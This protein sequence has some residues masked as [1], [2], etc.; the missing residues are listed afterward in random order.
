MIWCHI[1]LYSIW[2]E[3]D[4]YGLVPLQDTVDATLLISCFS[5]LTVILLYRTH[6]RNIRIEKLFMHTK[7]N[8]DPSLW[9]KKEAFEVCNFGKPVVHH[10]YL[11]V[12]NH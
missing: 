11:L 5:F 6:A 4:V 3:E 8:V 7:H 12:Q 10:D 1:S 2:R 9:P